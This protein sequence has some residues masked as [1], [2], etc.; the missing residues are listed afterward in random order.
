VYKAG[1]W[2]EKSLKGGTLP[3]EGR[4][5]KG[6]AAQGRG[7]R[8]DGKGADPTIDPAFRESKTI[9]PN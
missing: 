7:E 3:R 2:K 8:R 9:I 6:G 1:G 4:G 5:G